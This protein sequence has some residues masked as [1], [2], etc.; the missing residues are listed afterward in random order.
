[1]KK[2]TFLLLVAVVIGCGDD[3]YYANLLVRTRVVRNG[4]PVSGA[5]V[6]LT[7]TPNDGAK[8]NSPSVPFSLKATVVQPCEDQLFKDCPRGNVQTNKDGVGALLLEAPDPRKDYEEDDKFPERERHPGR[9]AKELRVEVGDA[10]V[11]YAFQKDNPLW[12]FHKVAAD[13]GL[14]DAKACT[15]DSDYTRCT[16]DL[17]LSVP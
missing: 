1:M 14:E 8:D 6:K 12:L 4:V 11:T 5:T 2:L 10:G 9:Y 15:F 16:L 3:R 13:G 7:P 17:T